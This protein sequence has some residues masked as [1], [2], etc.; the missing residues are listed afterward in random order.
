MF[1]I[2]WNPKAPDFYHSYPFKN[3]HMGTHRDYAKHEEALKKMPTWPADGSVIIDQE[4]VI[5][6]AGLHW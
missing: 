6:K 1:E 2:G 4:N 3:F 5:I